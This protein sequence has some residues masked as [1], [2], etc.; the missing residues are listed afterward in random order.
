MW[1]SHFCG[2]HTFVGAHAAP[3]PPRKRRALHP[4]L[5]NCLSL[6]YPNLSERQPVGC[7]LSYLRSRYS[8][9]IA[10]VHSLTAAFASPQASATP[11]ALPSDS[12][13]AHLALQMRP[14]QSRP[15]GATDYRRGQAT[16]SPRSGVPQQITPPWGGAGVGHSLFIIHHWCRGLGVR[17]VHPRLYAVAPSGLRGAEKSRTSTTSTT[18]TTS[19]TRKKTVI[20]SPS[21]LLSLGLFSCTASV[22][23]FAGFTQGR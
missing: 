8:H 6:I 12:H 10:H 1:G 20:Q 15:E 22:E 7:H 19:R 16:R 3:T 13:L 21:S 9:I 4:T 11:R 17:F 18:S 23:A 14:W 2:A 5:F